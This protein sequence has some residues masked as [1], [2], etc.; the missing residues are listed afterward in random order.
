M[1]SLLIDEVASELG[2]DQRERAIDQLLELGGAVDGL[3]GQQIELDMDALQ[4]ATGRTLTDV[5]QDEIRTHERRAYLDLPRL[6]PPAP[7]LR[8]HRGATHQRRHR[9]DRDRRA[10]AVGL[11]GPMSF[12][13][14]PSV[15]THLAHNDVD[16]TASAP[17]MLGDPRWPFGCSRAVQN[18]RSFALA[19]VDPSGDQAGTSGSKR[20]PIART[21]HP[22]P[23]GR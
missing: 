5:E 2:A 18:R 10:G 12:L 1:D 4:K 20:A 16:K 15:V 8:P 6:G 17:H 22:P 11:S 9:Q 3:L 13:R 14:A 7:Q 21:E 23:A 19:A